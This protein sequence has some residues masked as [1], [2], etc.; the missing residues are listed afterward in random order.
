MLGSADT[1]LA[2][3]LPEHIRESHPAELSAS[4]Y[5][6]AIEDAKRKVVVRAFEQA[7]HDHEIAAKILQWQP[8]LKLDRLICHPRQPGMSL[9]EAVDSLEVIMRQVMPKLGGGADAGSTRHH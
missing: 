3:D 5:E 4:M 7:N 1:I 9:R 2:E 8:R 6:E